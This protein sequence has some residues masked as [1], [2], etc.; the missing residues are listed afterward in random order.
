[1]KRSWW[2][3]SVAGVLVVAVAAVLIAWKLSG[4][5]D[6]SGPG[7][8]TT[9]TSEKTAAPERRAVLAVKID[10]VAAARP[11]TG[12]SAADLVY[13][14]PVEGGLTRL[15]AL[16]WNRPPTVI[17]PVRSARATDLTLLTQYGKPTL[18]YSGAAPELLPSLHSASL[19]NGSPAESPNAYFRDDGRPSPHNLYLHPE[20][21]PDSE[22]VPVNALP[23]AGPAPEAGAPASAA[24]IRFPAAS[25]A[26][27]WSAQAGRWLISLD[28]S[29]LTSTGAGQVGTATVVEQRV[30]VRLGE[31]GET[32][33]VP[34]SPIARTIGGGQAT[35]WR[36]GKRFP[37]VWE[38]ANEQAPTRFRTTSGQPLPVADGP[39]WILLVPA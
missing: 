22:P 23:E 10:N 3:A 2:V 35:V 25:F 16:Y 4:E 14:E 5:P 1:M 15:L 13:V 24:T 6:G 38:R 7:P 19:V 18:A 29:P 37:A 28:G 33:T 21:V 34:N 31:R 8:A 9:A 20:Q 39:L 17:G 32:G 36:D 30:A 12:L 11:Q 26:F 27:T